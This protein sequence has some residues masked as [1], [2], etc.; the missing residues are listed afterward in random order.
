MVGRLGDKSEKPN[1]QNQQLNELQAANLDPV[2]KENIANE[3]LRL[4]RRHPEWRKVRAM[5]KA[6]EKFGIQF[7]FTDK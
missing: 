5:R 7:E 3:Y 6:G 4:C 2:L 1:V